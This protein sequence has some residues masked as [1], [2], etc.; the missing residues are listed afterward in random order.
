MSLA[1]VASM[2][3]STTFKTIVVCEVVVVLVTLL[4]SK[5]NVVF[6]MIALLTLYLAGFL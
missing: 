6:I 4:C 2:S 1:F 5:H 3:T